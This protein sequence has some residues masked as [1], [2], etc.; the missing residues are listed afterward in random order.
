MHNK[1]ILILGMVFFSLG[2]IAGLIGA[3]FAFSRWHFSQNSFPVTATITEMHRGFEGSHRVYIQYDANGQA[4]NTHLNWSSS[5][6]RVRG[7]IELLVS[8]Q[9]PYRVRSAGIVGWLG[10]II[11]LSLALPFGGIGTGFLI[12]TMRKHRLHQW[13]L[14][15]GT[16]VWADVQGTEANWSIQVNGRPATVLVAT[17]KNM[18]FTSRA[19]NNSELIHVGDRVKVLIHPD[20]ANKYTFD[21]MNECQREP[22]D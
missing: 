18:R 4:I 1:I 22:L 21:F 14:Y 3:G 17:Y 2:L 11:P 20:N 5:N 16:P 19:I 7:T 15:Y 6:M 12:Y 8:N 13:L 9:D 10:V